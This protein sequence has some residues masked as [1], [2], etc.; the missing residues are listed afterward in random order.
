L[1]K[2]LATPICQKLSLTT[3]VGSAIN[4]SLKYLI[5]KFPDLSF[6]GL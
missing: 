3:I 5:Y 6:L 1:K 2:A 4:E